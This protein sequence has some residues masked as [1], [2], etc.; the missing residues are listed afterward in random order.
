MLGPG[1]PVK[2][3]LDSGLAPR[4]GPHGVSKT[5]CGF[6][7]VRALVPAQ[8]RYPEPGPRRT[9]IASGTR[10]EVHLE[11]RDQNPGRTPPAI[12]GPASGNAALP[13]PLQLRRHNMDSDVSLVGALSPGKV[14]A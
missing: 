2:S 12:P 4:E 11:G 1:W 5:Q 10:H 14:T 13:F 6:H 8:L 7:A 9:H 3:A